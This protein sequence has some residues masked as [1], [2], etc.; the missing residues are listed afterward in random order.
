MARNG[1]PS[2]APASIGGLIRSTPWQ[3]RIEIDRGM[4]RV[5]PRREPPRD[6]Y[7]YVLRREIPHSR[8]SF[9]ADMLHRYLATP[10]LPN[11]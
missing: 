8:W 4:E 10:P 3:L 6:S 1:P 7:A 11:L 9:E 2:L 5:V